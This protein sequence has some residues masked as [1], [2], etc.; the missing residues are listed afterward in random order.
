MTRWV[1]CK[2]GSLTVRYIL[3]GLLGVFLLS[4]LI[5]MAVEWYVGRDER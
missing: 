4:V 1:L 5:G 3:L 2:L